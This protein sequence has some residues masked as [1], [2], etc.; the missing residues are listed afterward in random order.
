MARTVV[1]H[2]AVDVP[3][4]E[5]AGA[6]RGRDVMVAP[7]LAVTA[8]HVAVVAVLVVD[9]SAVAPGERTAV[10]VGRVLVKGVRVRP[11]LPDPGW[12]P[13]SRS[14]PSPASPRA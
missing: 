3:L 14:S 9:P 10:T 12:R 2:R 4:G 8:P 6:P 5:A 11:G 1:P 13:R 7:A